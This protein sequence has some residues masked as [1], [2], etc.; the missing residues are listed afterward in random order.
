MTARQAANV[1]DLAQLPSRGVLIA[2]CA[3]AGRSRTEPRV[4]HP[5]RQY[6]SIVLDKSVVASAYVDF[7]TGDGDR[8]LGFLDDDFFDNVSQQ[9]GAAI[10]RTV[11]DW[12]CSTFSDISVDLHSVAEDDDGRVL[13]WITLNGTHIGSSF[14]FMGGRPATGNRVAWPQV[15]VFRLLG[16]RIVEH[17]AVRND[18]RVLEAIDQVK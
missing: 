6:V 12:L 11:G 5:P 13:V 16:D 17:W 2:G 1:E 14:P 4:A 10:W 3:W 7:M 15:H 18:L 9:R 8:L